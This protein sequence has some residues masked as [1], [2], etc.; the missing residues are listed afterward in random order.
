MVVSASYVYW[1]Y[2]HVKTRLLKKP[3]TIKELGSLSL[4]S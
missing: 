3:L 4:L 1:M 2:V